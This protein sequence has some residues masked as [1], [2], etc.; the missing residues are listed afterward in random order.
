M[1]EKCDRIEE[2]VKDL[3]ERITTGENVARLENK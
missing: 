3:G 2:R 1:G